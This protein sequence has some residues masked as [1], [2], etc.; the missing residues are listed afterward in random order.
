MK[1]RTNGPPTYAHFTTSGLKPEEI[2]QPFL[3]Q[4]SDQLPV[5]KPERRTSKGSETDGRSQD[6]SSM[7]TKMHSEG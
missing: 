3:G 1:G 2:P 6:A 5:K 4:H 7:R